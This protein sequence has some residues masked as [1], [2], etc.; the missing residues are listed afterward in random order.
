MKALFL[1]L[2]FSTSM[3]FA[4][5]AA[6]GSRPM[7]SEAAEQ[8][9]QEL[10]LEQENNCCH[11]PNQIASLF[12]DESSLSAYHWLVI[13]IDENLELEDGSIWQ[14]DNW[15][16]WKMDDWRADD[17]LI[18]TQNPAWYSTFRYQV[19]NQNSGAFLPVNLQVGPSL[20]NNLTL[21]ISAIDTTQS[22]LTLSDNS[23]WFI[24]NRDL[25]IFSDWLVDDTIIVGLN[26]GWDASCENILINRNMDN[27]I[28]AQ[29]I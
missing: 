26:I 12:P 6:I 16:G 1:T 9:L 17:A 23:E 25:Q 15:K 29:K 2:L 14:L 7:S 4:D 27:F 24:S 21:T 19:I 5:S 8:F 3:L 18:I 22:Q 20:S 28:R 10:A 13:M 11:S